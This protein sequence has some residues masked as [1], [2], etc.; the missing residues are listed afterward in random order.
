M[1][2]L[3][4]GMLVIGLIAI[5]TISFAQE[6]KVIK[7]KQTPGEFNKTELKLEAGQP[8]VFD[9]ENKSVN[10]PVGFV[11]APVGMTDENHHIKE[12]YIS[13]MVDEGQS[14]KSNEVVLEKGE[15]VYFCPMNPTPEYKITV[16]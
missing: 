13:K 10:H 4:K 9:V 11:I 1:K 8:Y 6:T 3:I 16:D 14:A 5:S 7:L 2:N 15:Y 12:A